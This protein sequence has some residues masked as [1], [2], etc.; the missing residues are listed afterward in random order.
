MTV[1]RCKVKLLSSWFLYFHILYHLQS[2]VPV[3]IGAYLKSRL[4]TM[5]NPIHQSSHSP[6]LGNPLTLFFPNANGNPA[7]PCL[8][9]QTMSNTKRVLMYVVPVTLFSF[10]LNAP[11]FMEVS[12]ENLCS[13]IKYFPA[14]AA[15][16]LTWPLLIMDSSTGVRVELNLAAG[17]QWRWRPV[18]AHWS[19]GVS[20]PSWQWQ[21][22]TSH[23]YCLCTENISNLLH[24]FCLIQSNKYKDIALPPRKNTSFLAWS[25]C[26]Q[27]AL[28]FYLCSPNPDPPIFSWKSLR[29]H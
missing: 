5:A 27:W 28:I 19:S 22:V 16:L 26:Q 4:Q 10:A 13:V 2:S 29:D 25:S 15:L 9:P 12:G 18:S 17:L 8:Y 1:I 7:N 11:K 3:R 14:A 23:I 21:Y 24:C 20:R 6:S